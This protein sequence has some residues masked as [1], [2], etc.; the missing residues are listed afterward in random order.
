[1]ISFARNFSDLYKEIDKKD[2]DQKK[3][4]QMVAT[5]KNQSIRYYKDYN[6]PTD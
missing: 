1:V 4:D 5:L 6:A 2:A 3:V